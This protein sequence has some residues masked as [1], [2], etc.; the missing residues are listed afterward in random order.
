M[1]TTQPS[2]AN[3]DEFFK[4]LLDFRTI[5]FSRPTASGKSALD[6]YSRTRLDHRPRL[7]ELQGLARMI[8]LGGAV[9]TLDLLR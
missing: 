1:V 3:V 7:L 5:A 2:F 9:L 4:S 6:I 8:L